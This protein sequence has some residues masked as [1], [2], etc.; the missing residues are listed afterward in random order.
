MAGDGVG[1]SQRDT[2]KL[3]PTQRGS[4]AS[5]VRKPAYEASSPGAEHQAL[6][7]GLS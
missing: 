2:R 5:L 6:L 7:P 4:K 1:V 3:Q